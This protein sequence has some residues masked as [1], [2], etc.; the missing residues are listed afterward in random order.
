MEATRILLSTRKGLIVFERGA[1]GW[2]LAREHFTAAR[3]SY[4]FEDPRTETLWVC[5]DH[6]H[7]GTKLHRSRDHGRT[8]E[9]VDT[10]AYPAGE[11]M[12]RALGLSETNEV[13]RAGSPARLYRMWTIVPGSAAQPD[14]LYMGTEPGGLFS[15][16]DG[17]MSWSLNLGLWQ[18]PSQPEWAGAGTDYAALHSIV[19]DPITRRSPARSMPWRRIRS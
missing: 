8:F 17:G 7:W 4:A 5:L 11:Q 6:G 15:S 2:K 16:D 10:P 18:H 9:E 14:R 12:H 13:L 19:V 3:V 1:G